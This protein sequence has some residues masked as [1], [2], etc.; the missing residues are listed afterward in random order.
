MMKNLVI[1]GAGTGGTLL[2]NR[3]VGRL[4][5]E[6]TTSIVDPSLEH[7]Y[8][9]GLLFLPF[10]AHDESKM[11]RPRG[12]TLSKNV[13]WVQRAARHI[14]TEGR[15]VSFDDGTELPYDILVIATGC[16]IRPDL[17]E[18]MLDPVG[19][20]RSIFD[21]YTLDGAQKLRDALAAFQSGRIVID[22]V[23]M[24]IKCP[25]A[26]LEFIFLAD[27]YFTERGLRD[28]VELVYVTP[29][30]GA[31]TKP[32][33]K[34]AL[35]HLL[36][37][38]NVRVESEFAT[39]AID[40]ERRIL[41]SYDDRE[42]PYDLLVTV[43]THSGAAVIEASG[44]GDELA[45]VPTDHHTLAAKGL[46]NVFVLGDAT[47]LPSSK[48]GSVAHF[49][50]EGLAENI[51]RAAEGRP[52]EDVFDGHAN[53]FVETGHGKAMLIDFNYETEPLPGSYPLPGVGP[54]SLLEESRLNHV[55][56]LGF[57]WMYWNGLLPAR[58][59]PVPA[60]MSMAGKRVPH[61]DAR[62]DAQ[63]ED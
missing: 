49:Q 10:G 56:K 57:R 61:D 53:C 24:P 60:R 25:V 51:V 36:E 19:W 17:T 63:K 40:A 3:L 7:I 44:L 18:G 9:P 16:R 20:Q 43:P 32:V 28:Q 33:A 38:K 30:D 5:S 22:V 41:R 52:I 12:P 13:T 1:L 48:A 54:F 55:G 35:G 15:R 58:P 62:S 59:M 39:G 23:E 21:F 26:P 14:D 47:D 31:F 6:W 11:L 42:I 4:S 8:Q 29:L 50:G 27:A 46:Q 37:E 45:F 2:A 34:H